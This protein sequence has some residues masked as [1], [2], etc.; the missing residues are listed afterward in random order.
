VLKASAIIAEAEAEVGIRDP[1][2][3]PRRNLER[4][5]QSLASE[6]PM[7]EA[8]EETVRKGLVRDAVN[9]LHAIL[10]MRDYPE[11]AKVIIESPVFLM[12]L[13]RSGTTYL[14]YLFDRDAR[15]RLIR[16]WEASTPWPP[17]GFAPETVNERRAI[18]HN[19]RRSEK[20]T[21]NFDAMHLLDDGGPDECHKFL[22]HGYGAVGIDNTTRAPGYFD[23]LLDEADLAQAYRIHK[24]QLQLL[25]WRCETKPWA[26]KYPNHVI[27]LDE[28]L[29][30]YPDAR[31]VMTHRDP[32]QILASIAKMTH[33]IRQGR[34]AGPL[35]K[36][37]TGR[38]MLHFIS[39][40]IERILAFDSGP[41][42]GRIVHAD[43][44]AL[45]ADPVA[46][47]RRIHTG[48]GIN[49]PASVADAIAAWFAANPKNKRG[50]NDYALSEYGLDE[51]E[52]AERFAPYI[53]R[54]S[55]PREHEGLA[56][57]YS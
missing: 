32:V 35:D 18:W 48:I 43:Y 52:I 42:G 50:A 1:E 7:S 3:A 15:F 40:H 24:R 25:Q 38:D 20:L 34:A 46:E 23:Y 39:R 49:T 36:A 31:L 29:S 47:M 2:D 56:R 17:P 54:F 8:G 4:L 57:D 14:Q 53:E 41:Q 37:E 19:R 44:Y 6:F 45:L 55:I 26:L 16:T 9:R 10:W 13:P 30:V 21:D 12:G 5:C 11:V 33:L 22:Q 27:A 51:T 28:L